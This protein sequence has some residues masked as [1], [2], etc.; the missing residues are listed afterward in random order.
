VLNILYTDPAYHRKGAGRMMVQWGN[1]LAD[2]LMLPC[3]V[4]ASLQGYH[5]YSSCGYED[6]EK[7]YRQTESLALPMDNMVMRRPLKVTKMEGK[8]LEKR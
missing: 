5:L 4:E 3:W 1:A 2:Q 6:V 7:E 8:A